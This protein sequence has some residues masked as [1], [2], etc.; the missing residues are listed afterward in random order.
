MSSRY[1]S[2][3][4]LAGRPGVNCDVAEVCEETGWTGWSW[5]L[6]FLWRRAFSLA[7]TAHF[8]GI[9]VASAKAELRAPVR[10]Q[11]RADENEILVGQTI[12][13]C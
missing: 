12:S 6:W 11:A 3:A 4:S 7:E 13:W 5:S 2:S 8:W 9:F 1:F 10:G